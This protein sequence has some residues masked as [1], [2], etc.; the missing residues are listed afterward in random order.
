MLTKI[1][2]GHE[3][4]IHPYRNPSSIASGF[5]SYGVYYGNERPVWPT[6]ANHRDSS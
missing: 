5:S 1:V 6:W 3:A 2:D 4:Q